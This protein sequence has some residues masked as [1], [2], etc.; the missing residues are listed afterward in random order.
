VEL[1][2]LG[3]LLVVMVGVILC[4]LIIFVDVGVDVFFGE[5]E[6]D[7]VDLMCMFVDGKGMVICLELFGV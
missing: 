4:E 5:L 2:E 7:I 6:F 3:G 1:K